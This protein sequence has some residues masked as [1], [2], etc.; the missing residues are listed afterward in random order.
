MRIGVIFILIVQFGL[1]GYSQDSNKVFSQNDFLYYVKK[2]HPVAIQSQ[3]VLK[4]GEA[5]VLKAKGGFDP[6]LHSNI[7]QKYY[8]DKQYYSVH[9]SGLKIPTWYGIEVKTGIDQNTGLY[10]NPERTVPDGGLWY[11]G[12]SFPLAQGLVIDERRALL[13]KAKLFQEST[14]YQQNSIL[15]D[16]YYEAIIAYWYWA[17]AY[18]KMLIYEDAMDLAEVRFKAVKQSFKY[19]DKPAI[20]TLEAFIQVQNR[21][22]GYQD[23]QI[24]YRNKS[25]KLSNYLWFENN[26]PLELTDSIQ[27]PVFEELKFDLETKLL[28]EYLLNIETNHPDILLYDYKVSVLEIDRKL[29]VEKLKPKV[30]LKYNALTENVGNS[31]TGSYSMENYKWG[32]EF[33]YP[34]FIR[35]S[36]G[37]LKLAD[38]KI[39]NTEL[40]RDQ[41]V[42]EVRN[43]VEAYYQSQMIL[44][45]QIIQGVDVVNNYKRLVKGEKQKF[46][47]GESSLFM[48]NSREKNYIYSQISLADLVAE[49]YISHYGIIWSEGSLDF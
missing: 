41:K 19:G 5:E 28:E 9:N 27:A 23:A 30:D 22:L 3:L 15:N 33:K 39:E 44:Q 1:G 18:N 20:D 14:N 40:S 43:K 11:A 25:L 34:I 21:R 48:I 17:K 6:Y 47:N 2:Y 26:T 16:L 45:Q 31:S 8:K 38:L 42:L 10:M 32:L 37:D 35:E 49:Y 13:K 12:V 36:R 29:K 46:D 24:D 4:Q 7:D